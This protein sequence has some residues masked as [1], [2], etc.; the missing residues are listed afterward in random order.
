MIETFLVITELMAELHISRSTVYRL[1]HAGKLD[2][3]TQVLGKSVWPRSVV[4]EA[5]AGFATGLRKRR[6]AHAHR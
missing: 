5:K 2:P 4:E 3:P 6:T 1:I